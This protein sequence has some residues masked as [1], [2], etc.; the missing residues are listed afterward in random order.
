M[1]TYEDMEGGHDAAEQSFIV[2]DNEAGHIF[3]DDAEA[4][5]APPAPTVTKSKFRRGGAAKPAADPVEEVADNVSNLALE[6]PQQEDEA[7]V[8]LG[9]D[10]DVL[11]EEVQE[12]EEAMPFDPIQDNAKPKLLARFKV[13][14]MD[15]LAVFKAVSKEDFKDVIGLLPENTPLPAS[16]KMTYLLARLEVP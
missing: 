13:N 16:D 9:E 6:A 1:A 7:A 10:D 12:E 2:D 3:A 5:D 15:T 4:H 11:L 14:T 8:E